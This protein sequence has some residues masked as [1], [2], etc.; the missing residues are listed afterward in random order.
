VSIKSDLY[1]LG[2][3]LYQMFTGRPAFPGTASLD[4]V[5]RRL[6]ITPEPPSRVVE[7]MD[8][9]VEGA[10]LR[11]LE[12]DAQDRPDSALEVAAA[13]ASS[14]SPAGDAVLK[15]ILVCDPGDRNTRAQEVG[16][17]I[18]A[19]ISRQQSQRA[20]TLLGEHGGAALAGSNGLHMVF[21]RPIHAA[22]FALAYQRAL[23]ELSG[24]QGVSMRARVGIHLGE[25]ILRHDSTPAEPGRSLY[26]HVDAQARET[27]VRLT[28]L[29]APGQILLTRSAFDLA[30]QSSIDGA[31]DVRWLA[32]G[33]YEIE[34]LDEPIEL[35]E[36]GIEGA[37]P[38]RPPQESRRARR[39]IVQSTVAGWR[40]APGLEMPLRPN[41]AL[42]RKLSE[43][44]FG[45]VWLARHRKTH[46]PR[47][48]KFCYDATS[49]RALQREITLFRLLKET[50]G[51]R[52][53]IN[54]IFDWNFDDAPY[55]IESAYTAGGDL[56]A[57]AAEQ[58]GLAHIQLATR[59]EILAQVATA[60]A[61]AHSVGVLHKDVKPGN[62]LMTSEGEGQVQIKLSD[63]G[64]GHVTERQRLAEAGI[65]VVGL[66]EVNDASHGSP[67]GGTRLYMAPELL[68]GKPATVR[69][70][71]YALGVMLY[72]MVV[73]DFSRALAPGWERG[74][75]DPLLRED[76]AAAVDNFDQRLGDAARLA[77]RLRRLESRRQERAARERQH[78][79]AEQAKAALLRA[80]RRRK[81]MGVLL[82]VVSVFAG[83]MVFQS[84][85]IAR[86][87][88]A[89]EQVSDFLV[90]LFEV[91]DPYKAASNEITAREIL[92]RG[93]ARIDTELRDQPVIRARL[94]HIMGVV[95]GNLGLYPEAIALLEQALATRQ[96]LHGPQHLEVAETQQALADVLTDNQEFVRAEELLR[97]A[98]DIRRE[99][100]GDEHTAVAQSLRSL[101][102]VL[103]EQKKPEQAEPLA[104]QALDLRR[105]LLGES[106]P[107]IAD[108]LQLL[109]TVLLVHQEYGEAESALREAVGMYRQLLGD[110]A[111]EVAE[112]THLLAKTLIKQEK[113]ADAEALLEQSLT[114]QRRILGENH[115][116]L[117]NG[118]SEQADVALNRGE[119]ERAEALFQKALGIYRASLDSE[120]M[121]MGNILIKLAQLAE[122]RGDHA[123]AAPMAQEAVNVYR[124][125][126]HVKSRYFAAMLADLAFFQYAQGQLAEAEATYREALA[127]FE[128]STGT[129]AIDVEA[130][131][132]HWIGLLIE[133]GKV[134]EAAPLAQSLERYRTAEPDAADGWLAQHARSVL[135]A[136]LGRIGQPAQAEELLTRS[137]ASLRESR[138]ARDRHTYAA[139]RRLVAFYEASAMPEKA[140]RY[141]AMLR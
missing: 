88:R 17:E 69:A 53:D 16:E 56:A 122:R 1:A 50:L 46:E 130:T 83:S 95:Y 49:L 94:M 21:D 101:A 6:E 118:L 37:S 48:F 43:G 136:Y 111:L 137:Y 22:R 12:I 64:I 123:R 80:R 10:I 138:G 128:Q 91:A 63:F 93:A 44:G 107:D 67:I 28:A 62:V 65:T 24:E 125:A 13:L 31:D 96:K 52:S 115:I 45:E 60:L 140:A 129:A 20:R 127:T 14:A 29:A 70:D 27:A 99:L 76:I 26:P 19:T 15:A 3:V 113:Y 30:R 78:A 126:Q 2:L 68:E 116:S 58:G 103:L 54:R 4:L 133:T 114:I 38:L 84:R 40:P 119:I 102:N 5:W 86:E 109:G 71:I 66:T 104:R 11:C 9:V 57:W 25:V 18:A 141:R 81:F 59:L 34:G 120:R 39:Q 87:A 100:L 74:V 32:H 98:L 73:G 97:E 41:W 47:V 92:D 90:E 51:E 89:A 132:I 77:D 7:D 134:D 82:I 112:T 72:Q 117:A 106:H 36:V 139:L 35:F 33:S 8:P 42:D 23:Q 55:F 61:A 135:G 110:D 105:Q 108:S 124:Q 121:P 75:P 131:R 85:R 79:E